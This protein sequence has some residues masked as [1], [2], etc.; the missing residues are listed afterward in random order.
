[1]LTLSLFG[2]GELAL[3]GMPVRLHSARAMALLAFLCAEP[4]RPHLRSRLAALVW[5]PYPEASAMHSLRQALHSLRTCAGGR[6]RACLAAD[7]D[8][9]RFDA[10]EAVDVDLHRFSSAVRAADPQSWGVAAEAYRAPLLDGRTL[11]GCS[12]YEEWLAG[13]RA[14]LHAL[15]MQ[16]L[17]RLAMD[18]M[19]ARDWEGAL[20]H[21]ERLRSLEPESEAASGHLMRILAATGQAGAVD[22][23]WSRL[24]AALARELGAAPSPASA[25]LYLRLRGSEGLPAANGR[26]RAASA[27]AQDAGPAPQA[28][29][30]DAAA[31]DSL[32][33]AAQAAERVHAFGHALEL[34]QRALA[35]LRRSCAADQQRGCEVLLRQEAMLERLGRRAEQRAVIE[36]AETIARVLPDRGLLATLLLRKAGA[37]A[38]A[39]DTHGTPADARRSAEEAL[40]LFGELGDRP[41][42]AEAQ[43]E[44]GFIAWRAGEHADA[45]RH[46]RAALAAHRRLGDVAGEAS[47]LHNLGEI[48]RSLGSPAQA[49]A[50]FRQALPLHWAA[51]NH[52]GEILTRFGEAAALRQIGETGAARRSH[53]AALALSELHEERTMQ[54]RALQALAELCRED[55]ALE[56]AIGF[57]RRAVAVDR[58]INYAHG[59]PHDL[60]GLAAI[61]F[62]RGERAEGLAA[63]REA[64]VWCDIA[65]DAA[66]AGAVQALLADPGAVRPASHATGGTQG[67]VRSH[68]ALPEGKVYCQFESPLALAQAGQAQAALPSSG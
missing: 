17:E 45:L 48:H 1:M 6:L 43:R 51:R 5:E 29:R 33:S 4:G 34:L 31:V 14:R 39:D 8:S 53:E 57:M 62:E 25:E 30:E 28:P 12:A 3:D 66:A 27:R 56:E 22:A 36:D 59:L 44:L 61:H 58:A 42:E 37:L 68:L 60:V 54:S 38:L 19:A 18:R 35:I 49:L 52:T 21:A 20:G 24:R 55:G 16:N 63:L 41:G 26:A 65:G 9:V 40:T 2:P 15:A 23:E 11:P 32:V 7:P 46:A 10:G 64:L 13:T 47:A 67:C 50:L